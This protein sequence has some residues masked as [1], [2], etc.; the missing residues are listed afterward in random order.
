[1]TDHETNLKIVDDLLALEKK[2]VNDWNV[3]YPALFNFLQTM[4]T[5]LCASLKCASPDFFTIHFQGIQ[6]QQASAYIMTNRTTQF[7]IGAELLKKYLVNHDPKKAH[8]NYQALRWVVAHELGHLADPVFNMFARTYFVRNFIEN[9]CLFAFLFAGG[10]MILNNTSH[11]LFVGMA[12][13]MIVKKIFLI[14]LHRKFEYNADRISLQAVPGIELK[15]IE[16]TLRS[17]QNAIMPLCHM[18]T[19]TK[20]YRFV[21]VYFPALCNSSWYKKIVEMTFFYLHPSLNRR[22]KKLASC[23]LLQTKKN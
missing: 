14:L 17:M 12:S 22:M 10:N 11:A 20:L 5:E 1:M 4:V 8:E 18:D 16:K 15:V 23:M 21:G 9:A 13:F 7:H 6:A 19:T 3:V 2:P